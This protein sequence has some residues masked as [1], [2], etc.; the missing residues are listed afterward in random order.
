M[1]RFR[2]EAVCVKDVCWCVAARGQRGQ[3]HAGEALREAYLRRSGDA[4]PARC[5]TS[6]GELPLIP[7]GA[8]SA[9]PPWK[10][11]SCECRQWL[12]RW[13]PSMP[14]RHRLCSRCP[15]PDGVLPPPMQPRR[16]NVRYRQVEKLSTSAEGAGVFVSRL[17][18]KNPTHL[19]HPPNI[20]VCRC[21]RRSPTHLRSRP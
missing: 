11:G 13:P 16:R 7:P 1:T 6:C 4:K 8:V 14:G 15:A 21:T 10:L 3:G 18:C 17:I 12:C 5:Y 2:R 9:A 20:C 19:T